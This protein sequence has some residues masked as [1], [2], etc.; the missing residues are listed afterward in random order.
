MSGEGAIRADKFQ[1]KSLVKTL[2][3]ER[4]TTRA[5]V[6]AVRNR[7]FGKR[8]ST[9]HLAAASIIRKESMRSGTANCRPLAESNDLKRRIRQGNN[10]LKRYGHSLGN[11][12]HVAVCDGTDKRPERPI[13]T[14]GIRRDRQ[15][16][17]LRGKGKKCANRADCE[18]G[19]SF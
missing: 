18:G 8:N 6:I 10:R 1:L 2:D 3:E 15:R 16:L 14:I 17:R 12:D 13:A 5:A 7:Q 19:G 9:R 4:A 11:R